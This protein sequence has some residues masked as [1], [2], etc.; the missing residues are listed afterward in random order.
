MPF[1]YQLLHLHPVVLLIL[2][3]LIFSIA[4]AFGTY[5]FRKYI[6]VRIGHSHNDV[7]GNTFAMVGGF[8][9][10]LLA[11]VVFLVWDQFNDAQ[12]S[13]D[14]EGSL[15][16]GLYRDIR[17]YPASD[18]GIVDHN[19]IKVLTFAFVN[20]VEDVLREDS[21]LDKQGPTSRDYIFYRDVVTV[22]SFNQV[23][24]IIERSHDIEDY[25]NQRIDQMFRHLNELS[26]YRSLRG[27]AADSEI[28]LYI[29][30]PLW[31][32]GLITFLFAVLMDLESRRMHVI[33]N[34]LLGA[35]VALI[36]YIIILSDHPFA[37][38]MRIDMNKSLGKIIEWE[39]SGMMEKKYDTDAHLKSIEYSLQKK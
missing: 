32:G 36:F 39:Y 10:L 12:Q 16:K 8:Y 30:I 37:G 14:I 17:F 3:M 23:F 33:M 18:T 38:K 5:L 24:E 15:A 35:F 20:Y 26:T 22:R 7:A 28:D 31:L 6:K 1:T 27:L 2:L 34:G 4:G 11:F 13:A 19:D 29:W 9:G 25:K 21:L